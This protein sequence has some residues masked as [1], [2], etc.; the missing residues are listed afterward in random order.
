MHSFLS[1]CQE[2]VGFRRKRAQAF[3]IIKQGAST[4]LSFHLI[5]G[6][7]SFLICKMG[8]LITLTGLLGRLNQ[9][10]TVCK[11]TRTI[12]LQNSGPKNVVTTRPMTGSVIND[13]ASLG[14]HELASIFRSSGDNGRQ[15][16]AR[17]ASCP[18]LFL[19]LPAYLPHSAAYSRHCLPPT[20]GIF[21]VFS[22]CHPCQVFVQRSS[23]KGPAIVLSE[24]S[25]RLTLSPG[26]QSCL[27]SGLPAS[28]PSPHR[29]PP[30]LQTTDFI[31][32]PLYN[33]WNAVHVPSEVVRLIH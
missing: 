18:G 7:L 29:H 1:F 9:V 13:D 6:S 33:L 23:D 3:G 5:S 25:S 15:P 11:E 8:I 12:S 24:H 14:Q 16:A 28:D 4:E 32:P 17:E 27:F 30:S 21:S 19:Y 10:T 22:F 20:P 31:K 26:L 2:A